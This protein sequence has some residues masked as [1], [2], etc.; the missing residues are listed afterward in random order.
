MM[1]VGLIYDDV[2]LS[3]KMPIGHPESDKRLSA[4]LN[5]LKKQDVYGLLHH[6]SPV[7]ATDDV[8]ALAHDPQYVKEI[9]SFGKGYLDGDT[10]MSE[11]TLE[12][13]LYAVG[14]LTK[15]VDVCK[16]GSI[17]R[18][19]CL[20]RPPGHHAERSRAMGFCIFNNVAVAARYAQTQGF[21]K[22]FVI[23]FDVHHGN[24]TQ[25]IFEEDDTV[26]FFSSHQYPHYPGTGRADETGRGKGKGFTY[27]APMPAGAGDKEYLE[28]YQNILPKL[29]KDFS[30]SMII[31]SAGYDLHAS[32]PLS[33]TKVSTEG[34]GKMVQSIVSSYDCPMIFSLEG[35][36]N[37]RSLAESVSVSIQELLRK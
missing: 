25:H 2:Y 8:I 16:S 6:I 11:G 34:I 24:G 23:D 19:F 3:H 21:A 13:S 14:A 15:A 33:A 10:Y 27:N 20:V 4:I 30:P 29:I 31:V 26:F 9:Y 36:Y 1:P 12:A 5:L 35:G 37:L 22:V 28:L 17:I 18:H 7:K 32:D